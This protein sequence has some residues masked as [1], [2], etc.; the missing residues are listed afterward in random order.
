MNSRNNSLYRKELFGEIGPIVRSSKVNNTV[1]L[2]VYRS[3]SDARKACLTYHNRY[4]D[5]I[6]LQ[7][8]TLSLSNDEY[9]IET[10][11]KSQMSY[12]RQSSSLLAAQLKQI[13]S[14]NSRPM[15]DQTFANRSD[16]RFVVEF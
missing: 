1:A 4:L 12:S 7:C 16:V 8:N 13:N 15:S 6:P 10:E 3:E 5:G 2:V 14:L 9:A 11:P